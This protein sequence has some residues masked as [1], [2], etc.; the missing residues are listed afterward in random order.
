MYRLV[1]IVYI[2]RYRDSK[3][4]TKFRKKKFIKKQINCCMF[5]YMNNMEQTGKFHIII[6]QLFN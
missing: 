3:I 6:N 1:N 4:F 2:A 5:L